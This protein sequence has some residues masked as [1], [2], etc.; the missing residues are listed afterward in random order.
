MAVSERWGSY[1]GYEIY[2]YY[3]NDVITY[4][5]ENSHIVYA[6][7]GKLYRNG[8]VVGKV[9]KTGEVT[10][11]QPEKGDKPVKAAV[12]A[13]K[14]TSTPVATGEEA[15]SILQLAWSRSIDDLVGDKFE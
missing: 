3:G 1:K 10:N 12:S 4:S 9:S 15:E 8:V 7:G 13:D 5:K 11:W 6:I 2:K 14:T